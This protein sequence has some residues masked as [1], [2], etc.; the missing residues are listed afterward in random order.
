MASLCHIAL[1]NHLVF[2]Q[3]AFFLHEHTKGLD[4]E[5]NLS[6]Y[7]DTSEYAAIFDGVKELNMSI[8]S[9]FNM[10]SI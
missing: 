7:A 10:I 1:F 4:I 3:I 5:L 2:E 6:G 9:S 8:E